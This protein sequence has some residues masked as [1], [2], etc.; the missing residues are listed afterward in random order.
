MFLL[1][2]KLDWVSFETKGRQNLQK[3]RRFLNRVYSLLPSLEAKEKNPVRLPVMNR[4]KA[5]E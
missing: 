2:K 1:P 4:D 5:S 3:N